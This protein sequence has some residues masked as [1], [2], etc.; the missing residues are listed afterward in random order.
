MLDD[1][2]P[3]RR[4]A[5]VRKR[6]PRAVTE[7][8]TTA[9]GVQNVCPGSSPPSVVK[10]MRSRR[11]LHSA[12]HALRVSLVED[13][14]PNARMAEASVADRRGWKAPTRATAPFEVRIVNVDCA[15]AGADTAR[16]TATRTGA[17]IARTETA[18]VRIET[19]GAKRSSNLIDCSMTR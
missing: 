14:R 9:D 15:F 3:T 5:D 7:S 4:P 16:A 13:G 17:P 1:E 11:R 10:R 2:L 12:T 8:A 6:V 18:P 19:A